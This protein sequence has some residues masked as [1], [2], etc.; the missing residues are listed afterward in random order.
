[1]IFMRHFVCNELMRRMEEEDAS[2]SGEHRSVI[3]SFPYPAVVPLQPV[4]LSQSL[5]YST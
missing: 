1:M 5:N 3:F 2:I 4:G